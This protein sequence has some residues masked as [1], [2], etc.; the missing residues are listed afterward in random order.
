MASTVPPLDRK[1]L[2]TRRLAFLRLQ[3]QVPEAERQIALIDE[4]EAADRQ[5]ADD[6]RAKKFDAQRAPHFAVLKSF[7]AESFA[8]P[9]VVTALLASAPE[10]AKRKLAEHRTAVVECQHCIESAEERV[11]YRAAVLADAVDHLRSMRTEFSGVQNKEERAQRAAAAE[12]LVADCRPAV[13]EAKQQLATLRCSLV[14]LKEDLPALE[15]DV[16][17]VLS[18]L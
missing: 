4:R 2:V 14:Q 11:L 9:D 7:E 5:K 18:V 15:A 16:L 17:P 6:A 10:D 8:M 12:K 13:E 1:A 3:A